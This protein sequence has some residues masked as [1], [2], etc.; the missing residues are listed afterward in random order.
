MLAGELPSW[1]TEAGCFSLAG[2]EETLQVLEDRQDSPVTRSRYKIHYGELRK[3]RR[4]GRGQAR[5]QRPGAGAPRLPPRPL[6]LRYLPLGPAP[7]QD[8]QCS[9]LNSLGSDSVSH[10]L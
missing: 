10:S 3:V 7:P 9:H 5:V 2:W 1:L 6:C 8:P 4:P